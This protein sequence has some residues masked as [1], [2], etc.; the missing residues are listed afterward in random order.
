M[1]PT[2]ITRRRALAAA[3]PTGLGLA[4]PARLTAQERPVALTRA[5]EI[6]EAGY[7]YGLPIVMSYGVMYDWAV[8]RTTDQFKAPFNTIY[9]E[10]RPFTWQDTS[11]VTPNSDTP[12]SLCWADLRAEPIVL[13]VPAV[14]SSRYYSVMLTDGN[15]FNYGYVGQRATGSEAGS[16]LIVGPGWNGSTP[17]GI[18]KVFHSST[19]FSLI[20]FRTQLFSPADIDNVKQVQAGYRVQPLSAF[21]NRPAPPAAPQ[22]DFP[23]FAKDRVRTAFFD[24]LDFFLR[25]APELPEEREI[26]QQ[27]ASIGIGPGRTFAFGALSDAQ[28][29]EIAAG[30]LRGKRKVDEAEASMGV[31]MNGWR[32][33]ALF[34]DRTF[35]N[36]DWL[37]RAVGAQAGIYGNDAAEAVYPAARSDSNGEALDGSRHAYTLTFPANGLPPVNAFWSVTMYDGRTQLLV[38]NPID[39]YLV[40]SPMLPDL[41]RNADGSVTLY[42]QHQS[43]GAER[44][45][46]WLP[47][48][49]GPIYLVMRLY[50]PKTGSPSILPIGQGDWQP[51]PILGVR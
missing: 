5:A 21:L 17:P 22:P 7:I 35:F 30:M 13:S 2:I 31:G 39:R 18:R 26:R 24:Y 10:S 4:A 45:S 27:L 40:N 34:G 14:P 44:A 49:D 50:W 25:Y 19:Q 32:V 6:A 15:T 37:L 11:V 51:P 1:S 29:G 23:R 46:N 48:P 38:R 9:N 16:Y 20:A 8:D 12:Y 33:A 43:P 42:I 41:K 3:V 47:A 28:K 36:G